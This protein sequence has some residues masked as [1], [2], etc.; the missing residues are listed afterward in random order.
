[1]SGTLNGLLTQYANAVKLR[2]VTPAILRRA[3]KTTGP[4]PVP[5]PPIYVNAVV[6]GATEAGSNTISISAAAANGSLVAGDQIMISNITYTVTAPV[7]A[8]LDL[9]APGFA[10]VPVTPVVPA[11][12]AAGLPVAFNFLLDQAVY[13]NVTAYSQGL[14]DGTVI[15]SA[16]LMMTLAVWD[17][18]SGTPI[19]PPNPT[20]QI[21]FNGTAYSIVSITPKIALGGVIGY[22]VQARA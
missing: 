8:S 6:G 9:S 22:S 16:D 2:G 21:I 15:Q 11:L 19:T 18:L 13:I 3:T 5:A 14:V 1:M 20:D 17:L 4:N 12:I 10:N 7:A